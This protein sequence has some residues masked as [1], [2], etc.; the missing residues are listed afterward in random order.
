MTHE[1]NPINISVVHRILNRC[2]ND[3]Q[4]TVG[5]GQPGGGNP[6]NQGNQM[7]PNSQLTQVKFHRKK[8]CKKK[9][10]LEQNIV[11]LTVIFAKKT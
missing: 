6:M 5:T 10:R 8:R 1:K 7:N 2:R 11:D 3:I 4:N 9:F